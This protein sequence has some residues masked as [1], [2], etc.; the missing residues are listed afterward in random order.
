MSDIHLVTRPINSH[1]QLSCPAQGHGSLTIEW[2]KDGQPL[3]LQPSAK[4]RRRDQR[5]SLHL[6]DLTPRDEGN[7]TCVVSNDFGELRW[8]YV[9]RLMLPLH[10]P[11]IEEAPY[12]RTLHVGETTQ[13]RCRVLSSVHHHLQWLKHYQVNGSYFNDNKEPYVDIIQVGIN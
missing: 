10:K 1:V 13:M 8:T 2:T 11:V 5:F 4:M 6:Y 7:Y 12:N 3:P 9:V